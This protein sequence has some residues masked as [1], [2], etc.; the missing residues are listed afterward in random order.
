MSVI[1]VRTFCNQNKNAQENINVTRVLSSKSQSQ[2]LIFFFFIFHTIPTACANLTRRLPT[3]AIRLRTTVFDRVSFSS[4]RAG[5]RT[6][7]T[8]RLS[9]E[10]NRPFAPPQHPHQDTFEIAFVTTV[11]RAHRRDLD[12][13]ECPRVTPHNILVKSRPRHGPACL[14]VRGTATV[15][16]TPRQLY[17][18]RENRVR[19]SR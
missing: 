1:S 2:S 17:P 3:A 19:K 6:T 15:A 14:V 9:S 18:V 11:A 7:G 8:R 12:S 4:D 10:T 16:V 13:I 5:P